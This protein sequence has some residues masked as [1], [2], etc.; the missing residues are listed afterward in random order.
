[1]HRR[2]AVDCSYALRNLLLLLHLLLLLLPLLTWQWP[3][4]ASGLAA[5]GQVVRLQPVL[6]VL[7]TAATGTWQSRRE[8]AKVLWQDIT[9]S[10]HVLR[11]K[12]CA[13]SAT[14]TGR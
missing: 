5:G 6:V 12:G 9:E 11:C 7:Q 1:M 13:C 4:L 8:Q 2:L 10:G 3:Q 14:H